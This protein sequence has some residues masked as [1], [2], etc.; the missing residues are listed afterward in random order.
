M[1]VVSETFFRIIV[2]LTRA[3]TSYEWTGEGYRIDEYDS[4]AISRVD[5]R[6]SI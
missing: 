4:E 3:Q 2:L 5:N 6:D 1:S